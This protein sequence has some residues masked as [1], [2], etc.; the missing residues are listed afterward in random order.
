MP[1][2]GIVCVCVAINMEIC[3]NMRAR[4]PPTTQQHPSALSFRFHSFSWTHYF[5][6]FFHRHNQPTAT[7]TD[8]WIQM[9][10]G[11]ERQVYIY[12]NNRQMALSLFEFICDDTF[13]IHSRAFQDSS[14]FNHRWLS[15]DR[16]D[17][18]AHSG[19]VYPSLGEP[20]SPTHQAPG[21][22]ETIR[23]TNPLKVMHFQ[24]NRIHIT[25]SNS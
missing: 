15:I 6:G 19:L 3:V 18:H 5:L 20:N 23:D 1:S 25:H 8:R 10:E 9:G 4:F 7:P 17:R 12:D 22:P 2:Q 11:L 21:Q 16:I 14:L 24:F 13:G